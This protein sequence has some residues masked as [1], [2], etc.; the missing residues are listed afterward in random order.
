VSPKSIVGLL[1]GGVALIVVIMVFS[2]LIVWNN[3]GEYMY[4]QYPN[5]AQ[6]V[7]MTAGPS[8]KW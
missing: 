7:K 1:L 3:Q 6:N 8:A 2:G 4:L 5:G